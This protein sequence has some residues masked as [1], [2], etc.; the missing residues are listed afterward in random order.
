M[1]ALGL[2]ETKG[3]VGAIAA[4]DAML[5]AAQVELISK[6]C[7]G[8]GL[9]TIGVRGEVSAVQAAV[10]AG[11]TELGRI[12]GTVLVSRH[13]IARP[14]AELA[15]IVGSCAPQTVDPAPEQPQT[16]A[17]SGDFDISQLKTMSVNTLR[18][19]ALSLKGMSL[20]R[21]EIAT[22]RKKNLMEAIIL[23]YRQEEE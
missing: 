7:V 1:S 3:L 4:A 20:T 14:D 2:I 17:L 22:A 9:V 6:E 23:A 13:V 12:A 18:H 16:R 11:A 19:I 15:A 10:D 5:K 8:S 21:E